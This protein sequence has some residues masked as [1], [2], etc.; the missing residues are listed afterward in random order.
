MKSL[1]EFI[2]IHLV[3]NPDSVSVEMVE[4]GDTQ[5]YLLKVA[6]EDT[7][8][9]IGKNG[10][11]IHAIRTLAKVRAVKEQRHV[12]IKVADDEQPVETAIEA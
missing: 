1:L 4:D 3:N 11:I 6:P 7:G 12:I 8:R 5:V 10:K 2:L 9:I